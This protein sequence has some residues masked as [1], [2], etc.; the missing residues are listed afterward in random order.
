MKK[1][2]IVLGLVL[3]AAPLLLADD[4]AMDSQKMDKAGMEQI[5]SESKPTPPS[6]SMKMHK[7]KTAKK[8]EMKKEGKE[9]IKKMEMKGLEGQKGKK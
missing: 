8:M 3:S 1:T 6:K 4:P 7:K 9:D 2:A 5:Q